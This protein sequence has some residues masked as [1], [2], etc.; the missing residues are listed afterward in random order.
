MASA[1]V[2]QTTEKPIG[3]WQL[4]RFRDGSGNGRGMQRSPWQELH[5]SIPRRASCLSFSGKRRCL[6][7]MALVSFFQ[8]TCGVGQFLNFLFRSPKVAVLLDLEGESSLGP[9]MFVMINESSLGSG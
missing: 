1:G 5:V 2:Q 4:A 3:V 9:F 8:H 6:V 7:C